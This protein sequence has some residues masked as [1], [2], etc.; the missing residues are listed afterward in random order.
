MQCAESL[1]PVSR[2][3]FVTPASGADFLYSECLI[4]RLETIL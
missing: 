1:S 3:S 2:D 4:I